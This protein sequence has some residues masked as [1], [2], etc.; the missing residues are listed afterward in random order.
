MKEKQL[1]LNYWNIN[2]NDIDLTVFK[3]I[4]SKE[5]FFLDMSLYEPIKE[6]FNLDDLVKVKIYYYKHSN[7]WHLRIFNKDKRILSI[8]N[9]FD[10]QNEFSTFSSGICDGCKHR[11]VCEAFKVMC[12]MGDYTARCVNGNVVDF[13]YLIFHAAY[14]YTLYKYRLKLKTY[15]AKKSEYD[16]EIF[17][18]SPLNDSNECV[19]ISYKKFPTLKDYLLLTAND[20]LCISH[21][22]VLHNFVYTMTSKDL[23]F[24]MDSAREQVRSEAKLVNK[25]LAKICYNTLT[26]DD[27]KEFGGQTEFE[28][29]L[30]LREY[31]DYP[32]PPSELDR[33]TQCIINDCKEEINKF[34]YDEAITE[35]QQDMPVADT[36]EESKP[37]L[38]EENSL[39]VD[40][41]LPNLDESIEEED[42]PVDKLSLLAEGFDIV[43]VVNGYII[44]FR[45]Y[46]SS[47]EKYIVG[48]R[49]LKY[50]SYSEVLDILLDLQNA[51]LTGKC[52]NS[53]ALSIYK[54]LGVYRDNI[55]KEY[56]S[57]LTEAD[58]ELTIR[59]KR[60]SQLEK[61]NKELKA[62]LESLLMSKNKE[63]SDSYEY[64]DS[65]VDELWS[66]E[67]NH[68]LLESAKYSLKQLENIS[69]TKNRRSVDVLKDYVSENSDSDYP[70]LVYKSLKKAFID[71]ES[72]ST[73]KTILNSVGLDIEKGNNNH[74]K[75]YPKGRKE[76]TYILPSTPSDR[77]STI[78]GIKRFLQIMFK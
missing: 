18:T 78:N 28:R 5:V 54:T 48:K 20:R 40:E 3:N 63:H 19:T 17:N 43:E 26:V 22:S 33:L 73:R 42:N 25:I 71:T 23:D 47:K 21:F 60:I 37:S 59:D 45:Y 34:K 44:K 57:L 10:T 36:I 76:Y 27:L 51:I 32:M 41:E 46:S 70:N 13:I 49:T 12:S 6:Y 65:T 74:Y 56:N 68:F 62:R 52:E 39:V 64:K 55:V 1:F 75:I 53:K 4:E 24:N 15:N 14:D 38:I 7:S 69:D 35:I 61:E 66:G 77:R 16:R 31:L 50:I 2:P 8:K 67:L 29:L 9:T 72:F 58:N 11:C 30:L